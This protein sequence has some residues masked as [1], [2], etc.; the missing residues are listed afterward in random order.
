MCMH[1]PPKIPEALPPPPASDKCIRTP[2]GKSN[3]RK[4]PS[5]SH[6]TFPAPESVIDS[7]LAP[8]NIS[9][10]IKGFLKMLNSAHGFKKSNSAE[11]Y[12][13]N[14]E[15]PLAFQKWSLSTLFCSSFQNLL[16][17]YVCVCVCTRVHILMCQD[18]NQ[19]TSNTG[20]C[21]F[22]STKNISGSIPS[23]PPAAQRPVPGSLG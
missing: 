16:C 11:C 23:Q 8:G 20:I 18:T 6:P 10:D 19:S 7:P 3:Q 12:T 21:S 15:G 13:V 5:V 22:F 14:S 9:F 17:T 2:Q 1:L 4:L